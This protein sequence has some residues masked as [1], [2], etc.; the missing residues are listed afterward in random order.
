MVVETTFLAEEHSVSTRCFINRVFIVVLFLASVP[1]EAQ[2]DLVLQQGD[3]WVTSVSIPKPAIV[4]SRWR[5]F[6]LPI[7]TAS[8]QVAFTKP[9]PGSTGTPAVENEVPISVPSGAGSWTLFDLTPQMI[10]ANAPSRVYVRVKTPN[11]QSSWVSIFVG[12]RASQADA[13]AVAGGLNIDPVRKDRTPT[14]PQLGGMLSGSKEPFVIPGGSGSADTPLWIK[15]VGIECQQETD[16]GSP[17]DE[18]YVIVAAVALDRNKPADSHVAVRFTRV[19]EDFDAGDVRVPNLAVWGS[20]NA[21]NAIPDPNDVVIVVQTMER[22]GSV[23]IE[24]AAAVLQTRILAKLKNLSVKAS[25]HDVFWLLYKA[26]LGVKDDMLLV[27]V[28]LGF[29]SGDDEI[30]DTS[31]LELSQSSLELARSGTVV[32]LPMAAATGGNDAG[33]YELRFEIA[34][35][36]TPQVPWK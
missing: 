7:G 24:W 21:G 1:L 34:R 26:M 18:I 23:S 2:V 12:Q 36:G 16:D 35:Q 3:A 8:L 14:A 27:P 28:E 29:P 20:E 17:S 15:L 5:Y 13:G 33:R 30:G 19:Y 6:G 31:E 10:P 22:D 9:M 32:K 25:H 11:S 4:V